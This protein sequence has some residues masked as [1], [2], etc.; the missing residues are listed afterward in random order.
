MENR[1]VVVF[2]GVCNLCN[3]A[4]Q[5][6]IKHDKKK[7]FQ[8]ASFQ[9]EYGRQVLA[10][11]PKSY[12]SLKTFILIENEKVFTKSTA[13]LKVAGKLSTPVNWLYG[14]IIVPAFIRNAVYNFISKNRYRWF[15]KKDE[16]MIPSPE[17]KQRF[18]N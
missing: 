13:A 2:D 11:L 17:L 15:G 10:S 9:G 8:F 6:V 5:F 16:C 18:L 4:V 12:A 14:F 3:A 1:P 7:L